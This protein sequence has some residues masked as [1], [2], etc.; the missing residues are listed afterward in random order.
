MT[1]VV[2]SIIFLQFLFL[3]FCSSRSLRILFVSSFIRIVHSLLSSCSIS[4]IE[5][6][7]LDELES[8][9]PL[10]QRNCA[11]SFFVPARITFIFV[12]SNHVRRRTTFRNSSS[13]SQDSDTVSIYLIPSPLRLKIHF[14]E[15]DPC[16]C[17]SCP[18]GEQQR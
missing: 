18:V 8:P 17:S 11:G 3:F 10:F 4:V 15:T 1:R 9:E 7:I 12:I 13:R 2:D 5:Y 6:R 16:L 14:V